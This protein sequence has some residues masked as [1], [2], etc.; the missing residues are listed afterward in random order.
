MQ[1]MHINLPHNATKMMGIRLLKALA[2]GEP[3]CMEAALRGVKDYAAG[4]E[5]F[6]E[7]NPD[8]RGIRRY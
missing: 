3:K 8:E 6:K 4:P 1:S 7:T 2:Y 5:V